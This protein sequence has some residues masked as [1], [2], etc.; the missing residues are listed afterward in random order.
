MLALRACLPDTADPTDTAAP[1]AFALVKA[2][3]RHH[4]TPSASAIW[5]PQAAGHRPCLSP[6][7]RSSFRWSAWWCRRWCDG[8]DGY[9]AEEAAVAEAADLASGLGP[10]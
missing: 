10:V 9:R 5:R 6:N 4:P 2:R 8:D 7:G 3:S 1:N